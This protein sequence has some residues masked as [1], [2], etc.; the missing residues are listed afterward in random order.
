MTEKRQY[1]LKK[2]KPQNE[3]EEEMALREVCL[4]R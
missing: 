3:R 4:V 1:A 2:I